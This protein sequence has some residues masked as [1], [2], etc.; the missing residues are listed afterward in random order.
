MDHRH[1]GDFFARADRFLVR[2]ERLIRRAE[3]VLLRI[4]LFILSLFGLAK[5]I[6]RDLW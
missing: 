3:P 2:I 1:S 5:L 6:W 4:T